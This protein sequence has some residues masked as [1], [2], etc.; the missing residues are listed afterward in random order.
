MLRQRVPVSVVAGGLGI[1]WNLQS[2]ASDPKGYSYGEWDKPTVQRVNR[3]SRQ[4]T[5]D[6]R[7]SRAAGLWHCASRAKRRFRKP[8]GLTDVP[9]P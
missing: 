6:Y 3:Q 8:E 9:R 7:L 2:A 1:R 4:P 5:F